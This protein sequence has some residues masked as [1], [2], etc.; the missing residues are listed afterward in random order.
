MTYPTGLGRR[1]TMLTDSLIGCAGVSG[2][3]KS[4]APRA[5]VL[6]VRGK[7]ILVNLSTRNFVADI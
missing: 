3:G 1:A 5:L 7:T 4:G 2:A 6:S